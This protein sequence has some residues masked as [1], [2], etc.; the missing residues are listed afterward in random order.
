[1]KNFLRISQITIIL[2]LFFSMTALSQPGS[3]PTQGGPPMQG[4]PDGGP[5]GP[6]GGM[7]RGTP[8]VEITGQT[9]KVDNT[10]F[11][12]NSSA[13]EISDFTI[14]S[15]NNNVLGLNIN[16]KEGAEQIVI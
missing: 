7:Q 11:K 9:L 5:G 16:A 14:S 6:P 15:D 3:S 2:T 4:G 8:V 1:M 13:T 12:G 10:Y